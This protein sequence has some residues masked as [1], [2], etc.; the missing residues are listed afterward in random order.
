M[1]KL[2]EDLLVTLVG[3]WANPEKCKEV[4]ERVPFMENDSNADWDKWLEDFDR[5]CMGL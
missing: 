3:G 4:Q 1:K 2:S 5:Y